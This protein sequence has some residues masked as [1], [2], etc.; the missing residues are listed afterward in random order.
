MPRVKAVA[1]VMTVIVMAAPSMLIVAPRGIVTEYVSRSSP[2]SSQTFILTGILAAELLVKKQSETSLQTV[3]DQR[4]WILADTPVYQKRVC[5]KID[6]KH[7]SDKQKKQFPY[8]VK[9]SRPLVDTV[10]NTR[11]K[12]PNG[13]ILM[14]QVTTV[15]IPSATSL[16]TF[17]VM[18]LAARNARPRRIAH[19]R[20]PT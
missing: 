14:I 4:I 17:W 11:P 5:Y 2:I 1:I 19:I 15:E 8:V 18:L 12:I 7:T 20:M 6:K 3:E 13:A 10:L 16:S 9:I